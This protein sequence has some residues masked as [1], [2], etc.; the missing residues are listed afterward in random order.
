LERA[1]L[2]HRRKHPTDRRYLLVEL[3]AQALDAIPEGLANYHA[4]V[5]RLARSV[6][7]VHRSAITDFLTRAAEA[8]VKAAEEMHR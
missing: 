8:A 4:A 1:G 5:V 3:S 6:P 2:V 7:A